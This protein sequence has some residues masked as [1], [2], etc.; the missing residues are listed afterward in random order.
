MDYYEIMHNI[1]M[2]A[3][4]WDW[5]IT[6]DKNN[7]IVKLDRRKTNHVVLVERE[8][9]HHAMGEAIG[10]ANIIDNRLSYGIDPDRMEFDPNNLGENYP[11]FAGQ[12]TEK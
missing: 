5:Q 9:I 7:Y 1:W 11:P 12:I 10:Q 3:V 6:R 8:F 2:L 4:D